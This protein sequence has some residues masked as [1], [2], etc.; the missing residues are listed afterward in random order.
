MPYEH[1][2]AAI[3][4]DREFQPNLIEQRTVSG[5]T[6][7]RKVSA[8]TAGHYLKEERIVLFS[9]RLLSVSSSFLK[10]YFNFLIFDAALGDE[11]VTLVYPC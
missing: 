7:G 8:H 9:P 1:A 10:L 2:K 11:N 6:E 5:E 4:Y 3:S